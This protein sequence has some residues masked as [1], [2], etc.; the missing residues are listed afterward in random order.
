MRIS[1]FRVRQFRSVNDSGWVDADIVTALIGTNE[2]GKTNLLLPLWKFNPAQ[3]GEIDEMA[4]LP[5]H[6]YHELR[7]AGEPHEFVT[8]RFRLD[9]SEAEDLAKLSGR[10]GPQ[11]T[12]C[13]VGRDF[14]GAYRVQVPQAQD[15][16]PLDLGNA[17]EHS[18][19]KLVE[20]EQSLRTEAPDDDMV[21]ADPGHKALTALQNELKSLDGKEIVNAEECRRRLQPLMDRATKVLE[22][23]LAELR[24]SVEIAIRRYENRRVTSETPAGQSIL[25]MMPK[26]VYYAHYGS[27]DGEIYLPDVMGHLKRTDLQGRLGAQVRTLRVL[28]DFLGLSPQEIHQLGQVRRNHQNGQV[29]PDEVQRTAERTRERE[30]LLQSASTELTRRFREWWQQGTHRFR[31]QAD[32]DHFRIWVADDKRPEEV[33]LQA[34]STGLQWFFS[35]YLVFLVEA[36]ASHQQAVLLLDEPGLTL[37]PLAQRDLRQFFDRLA[38]DNQLLYSTHSP[39][40]VDPDAIDRVRAVYVDG[41]GHTAV[42]ADLRAGLNEGAKKSSVYAVHAALGLSVSDTLLLGCQLIVVEGQSDQHYLSA[43]KTALISEGAIQPSRELV[44]APAG[45]VRGIRAVASVMSTG[46]SELPFVLLDSDS[47]GDG[48]KKSLSSGLYKQ[49][50]ERLVS[51]GDFISVDGAE[52]EDLLPYPLLEKEITKL[53]RGPEVEFDEYESEAATFVGKVEDYA[54][55]HAIV[56]EHGWKVELA[57]RVKRR[58][59]RTPSVLGETRETWVSLMKRLAGE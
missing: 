11:F 22:S 39:F 8:V 53:L 12:E 44:F 9:D 14:A 23:E 6:S 28:F 15:L 33:E 48:L 45:G 50:P 30:I 37:H 41:N 2:S 4:D 29:A 32:G 31:F 1:S 34:R 25:E 56:L 16:G 10:D 38:T 49:C 59:I 13:E 51:V 5:R 19:A 17:L 46:N 26:F 54:K 21:N 35:F 7:K 42:S 18:A 20:W 24:T 36:H 55:T 52:I 57:T 27:L 40:L 3:E 58:I 43:V 47:S